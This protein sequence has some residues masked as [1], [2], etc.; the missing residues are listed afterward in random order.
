MQLLELAHA[1]LQI[2]V[3]AVDQSVGGA[4]LHAA[5]FGPAFVVQQVGAAG[6]LL[7]HVQS[8][9]EV[10]GAVGAGVDQVTLAVSLD[11]VDQDQTVFTLVDLAVLGS[12]HTNGVLAVAAGLVHVVHADLG[13]GALNGLGGLPPEVTGVGL[14][15][16]VGHP[17]VGNMLVLAGELAAVAAVTSGNVNQQYFRHISAPPYSFSPITRSKTRPESL[18]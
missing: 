12:L 17:I 10:D 2:L 18:L 11:G 8:L 14:G 13:H 6:A 7:R 9:V 16:S 15:L 4:G 5:G 3:L 1:V